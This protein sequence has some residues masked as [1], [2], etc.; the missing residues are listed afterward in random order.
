METL[1]E[2]FLEINWDV[3]VILCLVMVRIR[4][5]VRVRVM[6]LVAMKT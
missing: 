5:R 1:V 6:G 3:M 2:H 4:V